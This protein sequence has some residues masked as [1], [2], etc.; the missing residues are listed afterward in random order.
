MEAQDEGWLHGSSDY[1]EAPT[2]QRPKRRLATAN[3]AVSVM[4]AEGQTLYFKSL[5]TAKCKKNDE[6][7]RIF[8]DTTTENAADVWLQKV[9]TVLPVMRSMFP[10]SK[11]IDII[12]SGKEAV[13]DVNSWGLSCFNR[14]CSDQKIS[15]D[16]SL[17]RLDSNGRYERIEYCKPL[18]HPILTVCQHGPNS[19]NL[20]LEFLLFGGDVR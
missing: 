4:A 10:S 9:M 15:N 3:A 5:D 8:K 7:T 2:L 1:I 13:R 20:F 19:E 12:S 14:K 11:Y 18:T 6:P 16:H 17:A